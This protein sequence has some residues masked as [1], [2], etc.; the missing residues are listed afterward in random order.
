MTQFFQVDPIQYSF[1]V[2]LFCLNITLKTIL[3]DIYLDYLKYSLKELVHKS[4]PFQ[5]LGYTGL[6]AHF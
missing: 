1:D 4:Q 6:P 3:Q 2:C 5:E